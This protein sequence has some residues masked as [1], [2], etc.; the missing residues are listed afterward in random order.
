MA[1]ILTF[2]PNHKEILWHPS[3]Q[4]QA[5]K[6]DVDEEVVEEGDLAGQEGGKDFSAMDV[7]AEI[8]RVF[9]ISCSNNRKHHG[10]IVMGRTLYSDS[11]KR[12]NEVQT[13]DGGVDE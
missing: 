6:G 12:R 1:R 9:F 2:V 7:S 8:W 13:G 3:G 11:G 10:D 5:G 4:V